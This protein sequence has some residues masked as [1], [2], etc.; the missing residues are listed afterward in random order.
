MVRHSL[1]SGR[2][3]TLRAA[4]YNAELTRT[5]VVQ[6][7]VT[8]AVRHGASVV[9][10]WLAAIVIVMALLAIADDLLIGLWGL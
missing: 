6:R 4:H 8:D 5:H 2:E 1:I 10:T 9:L 3:E 7:K